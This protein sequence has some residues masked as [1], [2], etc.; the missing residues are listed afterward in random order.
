MINWH[1]L[2]WTMKYV[3]TTP[4]KV[5]VTFPSYTYTISLYH[6]YWI[7]DTM[8]IWT[9]SL[10]ILM[11]SHWCYSSIFCYKDSY[12]YIWSVVR[13][14][15]SKYGGIFFS[16]LDPHLSGLIWTAMFISLAF[17]IAVPRPSGMRALFASTILRLIYSIGVQPTLCLTGTIYVSI[18][19]KSLQLYY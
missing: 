14:T 7:I 2:A 1:E 17:V 3:I 4:Y 8:L 9:L 16:E 18:I 10:L 15:T 6:N 5:G 13:V 19:N 11:F 12:H